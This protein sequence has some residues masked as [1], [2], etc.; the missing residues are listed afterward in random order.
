MRPIEQ[1]K[2]AMCKVLEEDPF[3]SIKTMADAAMERIGGND[4][5]RRWVEELAFQVS[6]TIETCF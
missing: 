5:D 6:E 3:A 4:F 1:A 2:E